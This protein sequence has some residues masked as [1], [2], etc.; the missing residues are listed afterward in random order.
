MLKSFILKGY[1]DKIDKQF[2]K[3]AQELKELK[4][5]YPIL[6][7][8]KKGKYFYRGTS[9]PTYPKLDKAAEKGIEQTKLG[10]IEYVRLKESIKYIPHSPIQS[11]TV[12]SEIAKLFK[13]G[14][15]FEPRANEI[16]VIVEADLKDD[17]MLF[18]FNFLNQ[19]ALDTI[20]TREYEVIRV[21]KA[22]VNVNV[23]ISYN[24]YLRKIEPY[25]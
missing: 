7:P 13:G 14:L 2:L 6:E 16:P 24:L 19:V 18:D 17:N 1:G 22:P 15:K 10:H 8:R 23:L 5:Y 3:H 20:G 11:W 4:K 25:L 12:D 9:L 21:N